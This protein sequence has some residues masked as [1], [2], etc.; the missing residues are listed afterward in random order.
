MAVENSSLGLKYI[1]LGEKL[2][3]GLQETYT[4]LEDAQIDSASLTET[5][6]TYEDIRI[7]QKP[8]IYRRIVTEEGSIVFTVQ[9]YDVSPDNINLLKGG[10][11]TAATETVGKRWHMS[12]ETVNIQKALK[13]VTLDDYIIYIPNGF[14]SALI[15]WNLAK[16]QLATITLTITAQDVSDEDLG[17]VIIEEPLAA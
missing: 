1:G 3:T 12:K 14:V 9:L 7:E 10:T 8:G 2:P 11:V 17:N 6:A 16:S 13:L 5:D 15:T 4:E